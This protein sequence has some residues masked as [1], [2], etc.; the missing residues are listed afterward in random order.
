LEI[1]FLHVSSVSIGG[2]KP[3]LSDT[4]NCRSANKK[5]AWRKIFIMTH[6]S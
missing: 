6:I 2:S 5:K 1:G 3:R 4:S